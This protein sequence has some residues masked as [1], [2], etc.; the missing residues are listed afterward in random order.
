M[1]DFVT[2]KL[3]YV[4]L[5]CVAIASMLDCEVPSSYLHARREA[6]DLVA[7]RDTILE[8]IRKIADEILGSFLASR[9]FDG[10]HDSSSHTN[11]SVAVKTRARERT[12][13]LH[14]RILRF[15]TDRNVARSFG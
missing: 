8:H 13:K 9:E 1:R 2:S 14:G 7:I 11:R 5:D 12:R 15:R 6:D 4:D 3:G 10:F